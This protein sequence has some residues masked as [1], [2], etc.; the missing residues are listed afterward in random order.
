MATFGHDDLTRLTPPERLAL[1]TQLWDSL[2]DDEVPLIASQ[3]TELE[4]RLATIDQD[5]REG[6]TWEALKRDLERRCP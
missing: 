6:I 3:Q 4:H 2:Q 5:R 1:I